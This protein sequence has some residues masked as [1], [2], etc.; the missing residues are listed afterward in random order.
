MKIEKRYLLAIWITLGLMSLNLIRHLLFLC[1]AVSYRA[2]WGSMVTSRASSVPGEWIYV[3]LALTALLVTLRAARHPFLK[4]RR[5]RLLP[6]PFSPLL[7]A[8]LFFA[9]LLLFLSAI[10]CARSD[11]AFVRI[12][13]GGLL[14]LTFAFD[15]HFLW[16]RRRLKAKAK[17]I[18]RKHRLHH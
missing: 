8:G 16:L 13:W 14:W 10:G 17:R 15:L 11:L 5:G 3:L 2:L 1:H 6:T 12:F 4:R 7:K 18:S 9:A